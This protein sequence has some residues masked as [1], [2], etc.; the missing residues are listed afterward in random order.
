MWISNLLDPPHTSD[1]SASIIYISL[2]FSFLHKF[3]IP[4]FMC[5]ILYICMLPYEAPAPVSTVFSLETT[6]AESTTGGWN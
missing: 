5:V 3:L 2:V 4:H 1:S 6:K